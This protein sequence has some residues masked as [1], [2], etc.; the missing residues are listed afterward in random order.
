MLELAGQHDELPA[1]VPLVGDYPVYSP[2]LRR[3]QIKVLYH[4]KERSGSGSQP[5]PGGSMSA[6]AR[7]F[8]WRGDGRRALA[9]ERPGDGLLV[10]ELS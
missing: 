1:M 4:P 10:R 5:S 8:D 6:M 2:R 7:D 9:C 3:E